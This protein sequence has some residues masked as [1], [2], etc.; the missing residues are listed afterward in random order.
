MEFQS[1]YKDRGLSVIGVSMDEDGWKS[2]KPFLEKSPMNY[3]VV[4]G[5]PDLAKLYGVDSM[6]MTLLI[7]RD[8]K[9]AAS[10]V[11]MVDKDAF[12]GEIQILLKEGVPK[13]AAK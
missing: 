6:P 13:R 9:I 11:G 3:S 5:N 10:H 4:V 8:G 2:V 12:D 7:D 1:K